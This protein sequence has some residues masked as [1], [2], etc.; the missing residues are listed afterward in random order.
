MFTILFTAVGRRVELVNTFR[1][2]FQKNGIALRIVG[3]DLAPAEAPAS[4]FVDRVI[5][6]PPC[7]D[8]GYGDF[9]LQLCGSEKVDLLI[10]L[11][12]PEFE[13]LNANREAFAALGTFLLLAERRVL[14]ICQDKYQTYQF[15]TQTQVSVPQ[16]CLGNERPLPQRYPLVV[17]PRRGMGSN[18]IFKVDSPAGSHILPDTPEFIIQEYIGGT[19]Y[20][21]DVFCDGQSNVVAVV[22]RERMEV[23]GGEVIKSRTVIHPRLVN[24]GVK[25]V[26]ALGPVGPLNLQCIIR[27]GAIYWLEINPRFGGGAP[28]SYA[29]GV[30]Y[31]LI[32]YCMTKHQPVA[33][34]IGQYEDAL[35][36]L[37]YDQSV[38]VKETGD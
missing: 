17:K 22:P 29:A 35:L 3:A 33:P 6:A 18:G 7:T 13:L 30:D 10:P 4:R 11:Y 2:S 19:E 16:T 5:Q 38:F 1:N 24:E 8:S 9:L 31:P 27:D 14:E 34:L 26:E 21:L 23:R 12:E 28:L 25:L 36:M 20:T 37:R 32:L 15:F